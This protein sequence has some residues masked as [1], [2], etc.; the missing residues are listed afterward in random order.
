MGQ[1]VMA[2]A[3]LADHEGH[4]SDVREC[5]H[6]E[7]RGCPSERKSRAGQRPGHQEDCG[8]HQDDSELCECLGV[9]EARSPLTGVLPEALVVPGLREELHL[10]LALEPTVSRS[11][12]NVMPK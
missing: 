7:D 5:I 1:W 2:E 8:R 12:R 4:V 11:A 9:I 3:V 10:A 6:E